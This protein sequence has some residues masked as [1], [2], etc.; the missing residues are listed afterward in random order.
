GGGHR[1]PDLAGDPLHRLEVAG[2][3][4]GKAGLEHVDAQTGELPGDRDLLIR[5]QR[6][7]RRLLAVTQGRIEDENAVA[8]RRPYRALHQWLAFLSAFSQGIMA[9]SSE[10]T[11]SISSDLARCR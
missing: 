9:R 11:F 8:R 6:C 10:P 2:G 1:A 5:R 4:E 3:G 7:A